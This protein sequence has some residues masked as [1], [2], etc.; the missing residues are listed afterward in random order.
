MPQLPFL[1][2]DKMQ[3]F[4]TLKLVL[5]QS[6]PFE[7]LILIANLLRAKVLNFR[8]NNLSSSM[9]R[10][11][12]DVSWVYFKIY[13]AYQTSIVLRHATIETCSSLSPAQ[14][15]ACLKRYETCSI[16]YFKLVLWRILPLLRP[17][18]RRDDVRFKRFDI[19]KIHRN[20]YG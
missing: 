10:A 14:R 8:N 17:K 18:D 1:L 6:F 4:W 3:Y 11:A 12:S 5:P 15:A 19:L 9:V 13:E 2:L 7:V 20:I 16:I